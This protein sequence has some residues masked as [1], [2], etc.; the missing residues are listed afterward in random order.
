M[1]GNPVS[2]KTVELSIDGETYTAM[3]SSNGI[4]TIKTDVALGKYNFKVKFRG[5]NYY[6]ES[7]TSKSINVELST[8]KNGVNQKNSILSLGSY[9]KSFSHCKG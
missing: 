4:A 7:S 2:G 1:N 8:F 6:V 9:L 3:T 5:N